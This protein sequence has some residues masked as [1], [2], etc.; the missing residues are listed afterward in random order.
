MARAEEGTKQNL[1]RFS[2]R[3]SSPEASPPVGQGKSNPECIPQDGQ[4]RRIVAGIQPHDEG[5]STEEDSLQF[6]ERQPGRN[7]KSQ[8]KGRDFGQNTT[9]EAQLQTC[10]AK[11]AES[12]P[13]QKTLQPYCTPGSLSSSPIQELIF[14]SGTRIHT[15]L[16]CR[17]AA[18]NGSPRAFYELARIVSGSAGRQLLNEH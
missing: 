13:N 6:G 5:Q 14:S 8:R 9:K 3:Q 15:G 17:S 11:G 16:C 4:G 1:S 12:L 10:S 2:S 18:D 7:L